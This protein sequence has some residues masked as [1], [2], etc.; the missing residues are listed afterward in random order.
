[1]YN[2]IDNNKHGIIIGGF[3]ITFPLALI[4]Y[5]IFSQLTVFLW[6]QAQPGCKYFSYQVLEKSGRG[7]D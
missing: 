3:P 4:L 7:R 5:S 6:E 1:M 2:I